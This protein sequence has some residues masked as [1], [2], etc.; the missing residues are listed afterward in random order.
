MV[1]VWDYIWISDCVL[2][3]I[4]FV[5]KFS[6][7]SLFLLLK[8]FWVGLF[9]FVLVEGIVIFFF[10]DEL[11]NVFWVIDGKGGKV[12]GYKLFVNGDLFFFGL[13]FDRV[14]IIGVNV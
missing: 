4:Y 8:L 6:V 11:F 1:V 5:K 14:I 2:N 3:K 7:I 10:Y 9:K 12:Y 13:I